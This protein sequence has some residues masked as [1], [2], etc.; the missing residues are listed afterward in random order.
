MV[1]LSLAA[2]ITNRSELPEFPTNGRPMNLNGIRIGSRLGAGFAVILA[3]VAAMCMI[4]VWRLS[5]LAAATGRMMDV[6]LAK[7]RLADEW[8]RNIATGAR[9]A[10]A[11]ARSS[12]PTLE[13]MFEPEAKASKIRG[14]EIQKALEALGSGPEEK[15][16]TTRVSDVRKRYV[17]LRDQV[18]KLK[19]DG[20]NDEA[21]VLFDEKVAPLS[22]EYLDRMQDFLDYQRSIIDGY[23]KDIEVEAGRGRIQMIAIGVTAVFVGALL[24][25]WLTRSITRPL[26][27]ATQ[28]AEA[29]ASGD[30]TLESE[31]RG[32]DELAQLISLLGKMT[33][34]LR[35]L[36]GQV[37]DSTDTISTASTEVATG[38]LDLSNRTEQTAAN[39]QEAASAMEDLTGKVK[40]SANSARHANELAATAAAVAARGGAVVSEV[41]AT[42]DD[43]NASSKK[44][45]DIIGVIDGIAFQTNILALNAAVE[46][47]RAG[48]QGRGF[49]V[50]AGEVRLLA[51]R[52]AEAAKEIKGLIGASV[53]KVTGGSR[54]VADAGRTMSEIVD[55]V[56]RVSETIG[57]ITSA[58]SDQSD[59]LDQINGTV[60]HLDQMTQQNAALVEESAAAAQ[61]LKDEAARLSSLVGA[62]RLSHRQQEPVGKGEVPKTKASGMGPRVSSRSATL[63]PRPG[64]IAGT[65][66]PRIPAVPRPVAVANVSDEWETF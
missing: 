64:Q 12:D 55:S 53:E 10:T 51:Q 22:A 43:I 20:R 23:A 47:A 1:R 9:R 62:F 60:T 57:A 36:V 16:L 7:E 37:R 4:G 11:I 29:V 31:A 40:Q 59:G 19:A 66:A 17:G 15:K 26:A 48:E 6:P 2:S 61:S 3:L 27:R 42:M 52:S 39:L 25:V 33:G 38:S 54:L 46:A 34:V 24:A 41:V 14:N 56:Q 50:V 8:V 32:S 21:R 44:I 35:R 13:P 63:L 5:S 18:M 49:A 65:G 45:A 28:L 30:L 58:A